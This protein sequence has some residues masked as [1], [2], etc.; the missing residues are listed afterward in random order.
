MHCSYFT[1]TIIDLEEEQVRML[2]LLERIAYLG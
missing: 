1:S 2:Y